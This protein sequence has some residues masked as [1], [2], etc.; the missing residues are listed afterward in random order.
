MAKDGVSLYFH[1]FVIAN[2]WRF[3]YV[4]QIEIHLKGDRDAF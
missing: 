4:A 2:L 1:Y 3:G